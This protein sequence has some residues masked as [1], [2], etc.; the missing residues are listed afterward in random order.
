MDDDSPKRRVLV[1]DDV[2]ENCMLISDYLEGLGCEIT[3]A[4]SGPDAL[5]IMEESP[6]DIVLLDVEMPGMNGLEVCRRI[7]G[8]P[9]TSMVPVVIV[10]AYSAVDDRV[11]ALDA[12]ADDF[13][14][15]PVEQ[16]ELLARVRSLLRVKTLHDSLV[17]TEQVVFALARAVEA[18]DNFTGAHSERVAQLARRLAVAA[19]LDADAVEATYF[20][21]RVHD[22]GK[23]GVPDAILNKRD[24]LDPQEV[25]VMR[26]VPVLGA[27]ICK[28]LRSS[29]GI[30][31]II[32]HQKERVDGTGYPD[33]LSGDRISAPAKILAI[34]DAYDS[35]VSGE[36]AE[37]PQM[38]DERARAV[39]LRQA[40]RAYDEKLVW[41]L[42]NKVLTQLEPTPAA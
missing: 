8:G 30:A 7:K 23:I 1:V 42:F 17:Q 3:T 16:T 39:L 11:A 4:S 41:L 22:I 15:K 18:K 33:G 36:R 26:T 25:E 19:G 5:A 28:P 6:A 24:A 31:E 10:T 12:G 20:A 40:G 37:R 2:V 29:H 27:E 32:R 13:L 21:A 14:A 34:C 9:A 35:M 38:A